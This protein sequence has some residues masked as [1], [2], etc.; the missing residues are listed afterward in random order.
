MSYGIFLGY[1][2]APGSRWDKQYIVLD[3]DDFVG[4]SSYIDTPG[5][6]FRLHPHIGDFIKGGS[7]PRFF[8]VCSSRRHW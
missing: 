3:I 2:L 5:V 1:R 4:L 6:G 7:G 8:F